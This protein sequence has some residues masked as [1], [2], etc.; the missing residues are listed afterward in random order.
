MFEPESSK[1]AHG[2]QGRRLEWRTPH[3][4]LSLPLSNSERSNQ[5]NVSNMIAEFID[6]ALAGV[7]R[8]QRPVPIV[9]QTI[10]PRATESKEVWRSLR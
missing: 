10:E 1:M 4:E 9:L 6:I 5:A 3:G 7:E 2:T 8:L